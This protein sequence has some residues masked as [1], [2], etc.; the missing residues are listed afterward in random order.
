MC[1]QQLSHMDKQED[2]NTVLSSVTQAVSMPSATTQK[3]LNNS[4]LFT[5]VRLL[6]WLFRL[7][8][9]HHY[10]WNLEIIFVIN[11]Q[12]AGKKHTHHQ[13]TKIALECDTMVQIISNIRTHSNKKCTDA[14]VIKYCNM[15]YKKKMCIPVQPLWA[16][17]VP[18]VVE[19]LGCQQVMDYWW[20]SVKPWTNI[21]H[22]SVLLSAYFYLCHWLGRMFWA[23]CHCLT[24]HL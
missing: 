22:I 10:K 11:I 18:S 8:K 9:I 21:L 3:Q 7:E 6:Q 1:Q 5:A 16:A 23:M 4:L 14:T 20:S 24:V 19:A 15:K 13:V 12:L 2:Y 17:F